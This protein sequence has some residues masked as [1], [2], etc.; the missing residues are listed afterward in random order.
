MR[1]T[2]YPEEVKGVV[3][4][5]SF[6]AIKSSDFMHRT[7]ISN[8]FPVK[9]N[10]IILAPETLSFLLVKCEAVEKESK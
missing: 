2:E 3:K 1:N 7:N 6:F 4:K 8:C 5:E 9:D 10:K